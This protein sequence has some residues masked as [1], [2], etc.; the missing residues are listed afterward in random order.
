MKYCSSQIH[1]ADERGAGEGP[2]I[3]H[4]V[5]ALHCVAQRGGPLAFANDRV[6]VLF[7]LHDPGQRHGADQQQPTEQLHQDGKVL[8]NFLHEY[9]GDEESGQHPEAVDYPFEGSRGEG[10]R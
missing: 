4:Q 3:A 6:G 9:G 7:V 5:Q 2:A 1:Q 8:G 10:D